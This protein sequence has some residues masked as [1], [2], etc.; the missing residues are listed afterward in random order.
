M[1]AHELVRILTVK[2]NPY[3]PFSTLNKIPYYIAIKGFVQVCKRFPEIK[4]AYLRHGLTE[5]NWVPGLSDIDLTVITD[6]KLTIDEEFSFLRSFWNAYDRLKGVFPML[7]D[8]EILNDEFIQTWTKFNIRGYESGNWRLIHGIEAKK[9][10]YVVH[11]A[12]L[13]LDCLNNA[14][15]IYLEHILKRFY[16]EECHS[17]IESEEMRRVSLKALRY[18]N[19]L[20]RRPEKESV[21]LLLSS[22]MNMLPSVLA[23]LERRVREFLAEYPLP[24]MRNN[25]NEWIADLHSDNKVVLDDQ[26]LDTRALA[27]WHE[28]IHSIILNS[29]KKIYIILKDGLDLS[30]MGSCFDAL[31]RVFIKKDSTPVMMTS[32]VFEYMLRYYRP[33]EYTNFMKNR[34]LAYGEDL[35]PQIQPPDRHSLINFLIRQAPNLLTFPQRHTLILP[36]SPN[37]FSGRDFASR[38]EQSLL[39]KFYLETGII[40]PGYDELL[41]EC[42]KQYPQHFEKFNGLKKNSG[43]VRDEVLSRE[44]FTLFKGITND[45]HKSISNSSVVDNLFN[46]G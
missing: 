37:G 20:D 33:F 24:F 14:M 12:R 31:G 13:A 44:A 19:Y 46:T 4:S 18:T 35:L 16:K 30:V 32:S 17:F 21:K 29:R 15:R 23:G 28:A 2:T 7:G 27:P 10:N 25:D 9:S 34:I 6:S 42:E 1:N 36:A 41:N 26:T 43:Y 11:S 39:L 5:G 40:R 45:I 3:P 8:V 38:I 22:S